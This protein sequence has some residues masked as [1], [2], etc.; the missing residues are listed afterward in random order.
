VSFVDNNVSEGH[1]IS[2]FRIKKQNIPPKFWHILY[3]YIY[4]YIYIYTHIQQLHGVASH[5]K[6]I[7]IAVALRTSNQIFKK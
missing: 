5:K 3:I 6:V 4:I 7:S 2:I 1:A